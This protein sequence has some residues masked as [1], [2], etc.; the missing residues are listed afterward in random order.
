MGACALDVHLVEHAESDT[1]R[2]CRRLC[3]RVSIKSD[4]VGGGRGEDLYVA[5]A[6]RLLLPELVAAASGGRLGDERDTT[7]PF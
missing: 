7:F 1:V 2:V 3:V 4:A 5:A 6:A